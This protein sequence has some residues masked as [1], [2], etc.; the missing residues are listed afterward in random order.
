MRDLAMAACVLAIV[1]PRG[2]SRVCL[3]EFIQLNIPFAYSGIG[4]VVVFPKRLS[5]AKDHLC[6]RQLS[7]CTRLQ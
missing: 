7:A 5:S 6:P 2:I 1:A 4:V 3:H